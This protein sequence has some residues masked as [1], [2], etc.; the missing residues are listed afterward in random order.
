M[1]LFILLVLSSFPHYKLRVV[2]LGLPNKKHINIK[3]AAV[4]P[5]K[6]IIVTTKNTIV[7]TEFPLANAT[8]KIKDSFQYIHLFSQVP[9]LNRICV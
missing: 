4:R 9:N 2:H 3:R 8:A 5:L 7:I 1:A 6:K